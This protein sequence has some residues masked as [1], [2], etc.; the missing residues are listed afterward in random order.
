MWWETEISVAKSNIHWFYIVS[1]NK[2]SNEP[3]IKVTKSSV[4]S[5]SS[6]SSNVILYQRSTG[7]QEVH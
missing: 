2:L 4:K 7:F 1:N 6:M 3:S 5:I